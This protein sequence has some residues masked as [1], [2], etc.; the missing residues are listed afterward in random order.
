MKGHRKFILGMTYLVGVFSVSVVAV[1]GELTGWDAA[2]ISSLFASAATGLGVI[3]WGNAQ[4]HKH[5]NGK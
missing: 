5:T 3:V 1:Y 2:G 4:E